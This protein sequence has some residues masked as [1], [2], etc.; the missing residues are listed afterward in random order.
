[1]MKF[2]VCSEDNRKC[3]REGYSLPEIHFFS[4][5]SNFFSVWS[6]LTSKCLTYIQ[7]F[8]NSKLAL[9]SHSAIALTVQWTHLVFNRRE[10]LPAAESFVVLVSP[11][12]CSPS[13]IHSPEWWIFSSLL[14]KNCLGSK[15]NNLCQIWFPVLW[16]T[17]N[18]FWKKQIF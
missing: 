6:H 11:L 3:L 13:C 5:C 4:V 14:Q 12:Q 1:M 10:L 16:F 18:K 2:W 7:V 15:Q 8:L 9:Q 17:V